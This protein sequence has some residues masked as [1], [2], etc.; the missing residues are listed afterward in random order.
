MSESDRLCN[1][2]LCPVTA[3]CG[4][5]TPGIVHNK[6]GEPVNAC[7]SADIV[8]DEL[9]RVH[10]ASVTALD[11]LETLGAKWSPDFDAYVS[12]ETDAAKLRCVL[13]GLA[14]CDC[15]PFGSAEY[16]ALID[17]VHGR[18]TS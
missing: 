8:P 3:H 5:H 18:E 16:F 12:G 9:S 7:I 4:A 10:A 13:C 6:P 17:R 14:P 2:S 11:A 15:P 1:L